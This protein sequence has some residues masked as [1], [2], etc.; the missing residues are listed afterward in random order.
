M[1]TVA[2]VF[3]SSGGLLGLVVEDQQLVVAEG[4]LCIGKA[5]IIGELDFKDAGASVSTTV[6]TWPRSRPLSGRS[7]V[8]ATTSRS[9]M[10]DF[11]SALLQHVTTGQ[12]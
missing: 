10:F 3:W 8:R 1:H 12:S 2:G 4:E 7:T 9:S 11:I 5:L 6:P